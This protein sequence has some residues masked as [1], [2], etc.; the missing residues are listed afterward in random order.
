MVLLF[1]WGKK[2]TVVKTAYCALF[3]LHCFCSILFHCDDLDACFFFLMRNR[4]K[5]CEFWWDGRWLVRILVELWKGN[6]KEIAL[7]EKNLFS[8]KEKKRKESNGATVCF[9]TL[10][11]SVPDVR[12]AAQVDIVVTSTHYSFSSIWFVLNI[13]YL[14]T[15]TLTE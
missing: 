9:Q 6:H 5:A 7:Y 15:S 2:K 4:K 10:S 3:W 11:Q 8:T 14:A 13:I 1:P 12:H